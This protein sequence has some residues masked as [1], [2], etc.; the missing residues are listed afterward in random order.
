[1]CPSIPAYSTVALYVLLE[2]L[3]LEERGEGEFLPL[4][5]DLYDDVTS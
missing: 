3:D 1:M 4:F 5:L 2:A